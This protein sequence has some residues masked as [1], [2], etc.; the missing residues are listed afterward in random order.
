MDINDYSITFYN[1]SFN[2]SDSC[3]NPINYQI[4]NHTQPNVNISVLDLYYNCSKSFIFSI[5]NNT[6]NHTFLNFSFKDIKTDNNING[7]INSSSFFVYPAGY[8][9]FNKTYNFVSN[10]SEKN[11]S[12]CI[13]YP[14]NNYYI[15]Y[16]VYYSASGYPY[17]SKIMNSSELFYNSS[18]REESLYL[19]NATEP[20]LVTF[21]V[22]DIFE[23]L[24]KDVYVYVID[25]FDPENKIL[26]SGYTDSGG[27]IQ[28]YLTNSSVYKLYFFKSGYDQ[29]STILTITNNFYTIKLSGTGVSFTPPPSYSG[30]NPLVPESKGVTYMTYP[31]DSY[32]LNG[33][34]YNFNLSLD[35]GDW[36]FDS[37]GFNLTDQDGNLINKINS[38]NSTGGVLNVYNSTLNYTR[39]IMN[40]YYIIDGNRTDL[41]RIWAVID[42][43]ENAFS[44]KRAIEDINLYVK[45]GLFGMTKRGLSF[46]VFFIIFIVTGILT[47]KFGATSPAAIM[48]VLLSMIMFFDVILGWIPSPISTIPNFPTLVSFL[49]FVGLIIKEVT[50]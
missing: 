33:T 8:I 46:L 6:N 34:Y 4:Y 18:V 35:S 49:I 43:S 29:Y 27:I 15:K 21:Q 37:W 36:K 23:Q 31:R 39:I 2:N 14:K 19:Y 41:N 17:S 20:I 25:Y 50:R 12:F 7:S 47:Y 40:F 13:S 3:I 42:L 32:L 30:G 26:A 5:C 38:T 28:F 16:S 44:I 24:L 1:L 9:E 10:T 45:S 11:F 22:I 48:G